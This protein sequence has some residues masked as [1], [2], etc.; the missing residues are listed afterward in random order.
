MLT[1]QSAGQRKR[2]GI[3]LTDHYIDAL[4]GEPS[5]LNAI[6]GFW[7]L[8]ESSLIRRISQRQ[9]LKGIVGRI[10]FA[11]ELSKRIKV[12]SAPRLTRR[13]IARQVAQ[14]IISFVERHE[15]TKPNWHRYTA[16]DFGNYPAMAAVVKSLMF[17]RATTESSFPAR[18][19]WACSNVT[20]GHI[21]L[22]LDYVESAIQEKNK[23]AANY[24]W[25]NAEEKWLLIVAGGGE[26][27]TQAPRR[28]SF[29]NWCTKC[30]T[31]LC[32]QS[33]FDKIIVWERVGKWTK[34]LK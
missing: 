11:R 21:S 5:P 9:N 7:K 23:K 30:L 10:Q 28:E 19:L 6:T 16:H 20:T 15:E 8:V 26:I 14:E 33:P 32:Q 29:I 18:G 3:E 12:L 31:Q 22:S 34:W 27:N 4:A 17:T 2:I 13:E 25:G 1:I 24:A